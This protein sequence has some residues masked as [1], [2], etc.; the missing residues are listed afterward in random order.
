MKK[1]PL[2][3]LG[4]LNCAMLIV[5]ANAQSLTSAP[6]PS[7]EIAGLTKAL[8][9]KWVLSVKFEPSATVPNGLV[10]S[11]EETWR[12][13]PGG[14]TLLEE[15]HLR[16]PEGDLSLLGI[17]W[18]NTANKALHGMEC[19]NLLPYTCDVKG[20]QNDVTMNWDGKQ[21]VIDEIETSKSG[22][23]SA[24][25]EV[26]SDI[27]PN[28]F[29]QTGEYGDPG[30]PRKRLFTIHATKVTYNQIKNDQSQSD[31]AGPAPEMQSLAKALK[32]N[33][34]TTYEFAP[35]GISPV[36]G[37][38][39]GEENWRTGPGGYVL[40]EEEHVRAPSEEMFLIAFHWW[41]KTTNSLRGMLCNNSGP[42]ACDFNTYSNSS[43]KWDGKQ[44]TIDMEFP[45]G[46]KKMRWHEVWAGITATSFT[47]IGE[48]GEV[49][50]PLKRAVTIRGTKSQ[51]GRAIEE[52]TGED[53]AKQ[54]R[55]SFDALPSE[56]VTEQNVMDPIWEPL[57]YKGVNYYAY[58]RSQSGKSFAARS[59][60]S[61]SL[62]QAWLGAYVIVGGKSVFG[63]GE[64]D[65]QCAAFVKLAE[66]DQQSW[67]AAMGDPHPFADFSGKR[68]F[69][70]VPIDG[71]ERTGCSLDGA[72]HSDLSSADTPLVKH[73]GMPAEA[74]WK[75]RV[76]AFHNLDLRIV[77]AW[78]YD[79]R[80]DISVIVYTA[81]SRF[82]NRAGLVT[83][84]DAAIAKS[85]RQPMQQ[86]KLVDAKAHP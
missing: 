21:F 60:P 56:W 44:L 4:V 19:Q 2:I 45:Q 48:M 74:E 76:S 54:M 17:L 52:R 22:K 20:A 28:S 38:G 83:D 80:R 27:T 50:G 55:A 67:L 11:G 16:T 14:F 35:G 23:K 71:S 77:G 66:Y 9:G 13:G 79:P 5:G 32:G 42:A 68:H 82:K 25:H 85:L 70:T 84:N 59:D 47:Q 29:T 1:V 6:K 39:T 8:D 18:W 30:G 57:G 64:K 61:S 46:G 49:G 62:Y 12:P 31:D 10:N 34:S 86:T 33:W 75:H 24:W 43:L 65:A 73:M 78:W 37:T 58:G 53:I 36:G 41:D 63:S 3:S 40:M 69:L 81:S 15:E 51:S 72:T 26:W 7:A